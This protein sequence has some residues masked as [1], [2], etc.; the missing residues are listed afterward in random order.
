VH[1]GRIYAYAESDGI[2]VESILDFS[3]NL[4]PCGPP[5]SVLEAVQSALPLIQH[6]P[7]ERQRRVKEVLSERFNVP[8]ESLVCGNGASEVMELVFRTVK[9]QRTWILE[10]AFGEYEAIARR[11]GSHIMHCTLRQD[12]AFTLPL[13]ALSEWV[14]EGDMVV[15]NTPHN[16]SGR[17]FPKSSWFD[18]A[19]SWTKRGVHVLVD[20]SFL[21][22]M[23]HD[24]VE[25]GMCES[26]HN[27]RWHTIRS[28][29]KIF[30]IPG[31]RFG[32]AVL[33]PDMAQR[34]NANRD[35]WSVNALAQVAVAAAY[36]EPSWLVQTYR[37]LAQAH[38]FAHSTWGAD[39]RIRMFPFDVN[40]FLIRLK[41]EDL[42][43]LIQ[44]E[45]RRRG[46]YVRNC[47]SFRFLGPAYI[48]IALRTEAENRTLWQTFSDLLDRASERF[49]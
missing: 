10:P 18:A 34:V 9:P 32:F 27:P 20:E 29:T 12:D 47:E 26:V 49:G 5:A 45:L 48:R 33:H 43:L 42:S 31:L 36:Q 28:A 16:P 24:E 23:E 6:Y 22:F 2:P 4:H 35:G 19:R 37:W 39:A 1:G 11:C 15:I 7:D 44:R 25:S 3:A 13:A 21:D 8:T 17:H 41:S 38:A 30:A 40:F 14:S 46:L